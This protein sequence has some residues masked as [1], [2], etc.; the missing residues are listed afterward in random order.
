MRKSHGEIDNH[1]SKI[2]FGNGGEDE[3]QDSWG[4]RLMMYDAQVGRLMLNLS[5]MEGN[6]ILSHRWRNGGGYL[7]NRD[8]TGDYGGI[9]EPSE[10]ESYEVSGKGI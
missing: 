9:R 5:R 10:I 1:R 4:V 8:G 7:L 2:G 6:R 3:Y